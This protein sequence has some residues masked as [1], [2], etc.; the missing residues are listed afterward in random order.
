MVSIH[1]VRPGDV[2]GGGGGHQ[3]CAG[4]R[5]ARPA[6]KRGVSVAGADPLCPQDAF[7]LE[8][9]IMEAFTD[10]YGVAPPGRYHLVGVSYVLDDDAAELR[11]MDL[12]EPITERWGDFEESIAKIYELFYSDMRIRLMSA[13]FIVE[14]HPTGVC[15]A[16]GR[17]EPVIGY[18]TGL[19]A[20]G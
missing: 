7:A 6:H 15:A 3:L 20:Q 1:A 19:W 2:Q 17:S 5:G 10:V 12:P 11:W 8:Q 9:N 18:C 14:G 16:G 4:V 13:W